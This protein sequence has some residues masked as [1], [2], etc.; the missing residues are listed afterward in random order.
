MK[1]RL[2]EIAQIELDQAIEYYNCES[3]G[4]GDAFLTEVLK[5]LDRIGEFP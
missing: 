4:L 2:L 3:P 1:I 5:A